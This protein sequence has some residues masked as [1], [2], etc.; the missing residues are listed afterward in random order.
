[1]KQSVIRELVKQALIETLAEKNMTSDGAMTPEEEEMVNKYEKEQAAKYA[2]DNEEPL[3]EASTSPDERVDY[4]ENILDMVWKRGRGNKLIDFKDLAQQLINNM[5]D[6]ETTPEI[7]GFEGTKDALDSLYEKEGVD[8][9]AQAREIVRKYKEEGDTV[10]EATRIV[11][12]WK[13]GKLLKE[14]K[15]KES[16][17]SVVNKH[18]AGLLKALT[19]RSKYPEDEQ[20][21]R[22]VEKHLKAIA[23]ELGLDASLPFM[24]DE[25][26]SGKAKPMEALEYTKEM[27]NDSLEDT[28]MTETKK[29]HS[30]TVNKH[31]DET[32]KEAMHGGYLELFEM[33]PNFE[34]GV[35]KLLQ[36]WN[37]WAE[38]DMTE[39]YMIEEAKHDIL[40]YLSEMMK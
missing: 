22:S 27:F 13:K 39:P 17:D 24:E 10:A 26:Y 4:L 9:M 38:G 29:K 6:E 31:A 28:G 33:N 37:E 21:Y 8:I 16:I 40:A 18:S 23:T 11:E 25:M 15:G 12:A 7:P 2:L 36:A 5:F 35:A 30:E 1:M 14:N 3:E 19:A 32:V 20:P 34:E